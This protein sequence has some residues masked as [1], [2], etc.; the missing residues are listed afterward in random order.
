MGL[1]NNK[2]LGRPYLITFKIINMKK[3]S[4]LLVL[5]C[6]IYNCN[7]QNTINGH[8][9][10]DLGLPSG[11]KWA[12]CNVGCND[13][14]YYVNDLGD[15][16]FYNDVENGKKIWGGTWRVPTESEFRELMKYCDWVYVDHRS[17]SNPFYKVIGPNGNSIT[18]EHVDTGYYYGYNTYWTSS[19]TRHFTGR[20]AGVLFQYNKHKREFYETLG[21]SEPYYIRL[22]SE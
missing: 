4:F 14:S 18:F 5:I 12:T 7:A 22:V 13:C 1:P 6:I 19:V 21:D 17:Y 9:Y 8:E 11:L 3:I 15:E 20:Y 10:V 16:R 2:N